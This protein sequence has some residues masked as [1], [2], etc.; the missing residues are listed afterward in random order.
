MNEDIDADQARIAEVQERIVWV[1]VRRNHI[2]AAT[3]GVVDADQHLI[4]EDRALAEEIVT[5]ADEEEDIRLALEDALEGPV[6]GVE[7][8][9]R[10][11]LSEIQK[12]LAAIGWDEG[13]GAEQLKERER[14]F[15]EYLAEIVE[16]TPSGPSAGACRYC[17]Q[18]QEVGPH[19]TQ[20]EAD[21]TASEVCNC[22]GARAARRERERVE[23]A[24]ERVHR[25]FGD[26]AEELG[27]KP[28]HDA[29]VDLLDQ[30]VELIAKGPIS[31]ASLNIRGQC[32]AKFS[33]TSKGKIKVSRSETRSCD[34]E[35][36][37]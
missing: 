18:I 19:Q 11:T 6:G 24:Q 34:L 16:E 36:G 1:T 10:S 23:D 8:Y 28:V 27:F 4:D 20:A 29:A 26:G 33:I 17:G 9:A 21:D 37:E 2:K 12:E 13:S 30:V 15:N 14:M 7:R 25:L 5:I 22:P 3:A 32:K 31:S 35:A